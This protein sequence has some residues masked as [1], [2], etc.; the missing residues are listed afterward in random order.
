MPRERLVGELVAL[1]LWLTEGAGEYRSAIDASLKSLT[2][3]MTRSQANTAQH[4]WAR[5]TRRALGWAA[6]VVFDMHSVV[7]LFCGAPIRLPASC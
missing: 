7:S 5:S 4:I 3:N 6:L 2:A 1:L